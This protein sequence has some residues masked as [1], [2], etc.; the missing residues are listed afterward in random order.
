MPPHPPGAITPSL[1]IPAVHQL[2]PCGGKGSSGVFQTAPNP[3]DTLFR[4]SLDLLSWRGCAGHL[5]STGEL[6]QQLQVK[7]LPALVLLATVDENLVLWAGEG[8]GN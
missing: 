8:K 1:I 3:K 6:G 2:H 5:L 7:I 4:G